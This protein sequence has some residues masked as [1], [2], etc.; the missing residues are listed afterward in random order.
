MPSFILIQCKGIE[1]EG[2]SVLETLQFV[3]EPEFHSA[4]KDFFMN[5]WPSANQ[6]VFGFTDQS[7][8]KME[9]HL[10]TAR[11]N[12]QIAGVIQ[13]RIIGG[14]GYLSTLLV[15]EEYRGNGLIGQALLSKF[16][17][18][19]IQKKCHKLG[20]KSYKNSRASNF[21]KKH[22]FI[23]EGV[24]KQDIHGIDWVMMAKFF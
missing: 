18:M 19:A 22:G 15:K 5:E 2:G 20:L 7:K 13:F 12:N 11:Q 24:L 16:E 14:V 10:M 9:E 4:I 6:E 23:E 3:Y 21:F 8:W 1:S 17:E